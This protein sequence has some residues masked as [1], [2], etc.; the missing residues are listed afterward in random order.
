[1]RE[2]EKQHS[3]VATIKPTKENVLLLGIVPLLYLLHSMKMMSSIL[4]KRTTILHPQHN[5]S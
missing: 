2:I 5:E 3:L 4:L 1:M